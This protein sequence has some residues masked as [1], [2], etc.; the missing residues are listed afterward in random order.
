MKKSSK[1]APK[2]PTPAAQ[3]LKAKPA[4]ISKKAPKTKLALRPATIAPAAP[5]SKVARQ[6]QPAAKKPAQAPA[7]RRSTPAVAPAAAQKQQPAA[8][9]AARAAPAP[10]KPELP[11]V[12][13]CASDAHG[14]AALE[15]Y[16]GLSV[17]RWVEAGP[18]GPV[19]KEASTERFT[20]EFCRP[21]IPAKPL[22]D[23]VLSFMRSLHRGYM[24]ED[25]VAAVLVSAYRTAHF[26][27]LSPP[28]QSET[29]ERWLDYCAGLAG[30]MGKEAPRSFKNL[31]AA[32]AYAIE[33]E[34]ALA[35]PTAAQAA[36]QAEARATAVK[37]LAGLSDLKASVQAHSAAVR[38]TRPA[39]RERSSNSG[40]PAKRGQ[41]IGT[42]CCE[43]ILAGKSNDEVLKAALGRFPGAKTSA[44]SVAWYRNDLR[45]SGKLK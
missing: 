22:R 34:A 30:A 45:R 20:R 10:A 39:A 23:C 1:A 5:K 33:L 17:S 7:A 13:R 44:S 28:E 32:N 2:K 36:H 35:E 21:L 24:K 8:K 43:L 37:R 18:A 14:H 19:K 16:R 31:I 27:A 38:R 26:G 42:Y 15:Y 12:P 4:A 25:G 9:P 3:K 11:I 6:Q 40:T 29:V 41:G